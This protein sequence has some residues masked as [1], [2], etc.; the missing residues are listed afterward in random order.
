MKAGWLAL[1]LLLS[2]CTQTATYRSA[3]GEQATCQHRA[4]LPGMGL[5]GLLTAPAYVIDEIQ[6]R[7]AYADCKTR[8]ERAGWQRVD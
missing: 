4:G 5:L 1:A 7:G 6:T 3:F 8:W 2:G